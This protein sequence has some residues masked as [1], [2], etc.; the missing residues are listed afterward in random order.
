MYNKFSVVVESMIIFGVNE[1]ITCSEEAIK[2]IESVP[3]W[4]A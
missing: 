3:E 4:K 2:S 1:I